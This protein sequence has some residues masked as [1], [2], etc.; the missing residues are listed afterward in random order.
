LRPDLFAGMGLRPALSH[1]RPPRR[2]A[3]PV[4][5]PI[6]LA[7][8]P[9]RDQTANTHQP[10]RPLRGQPIE[11]PHLGGQVPGSERG[12]KFY[13]Q[14]FRRALTLVETIT[15]RRTAKPMTDSVT[16]K[17]PPHDPIAST[18]SAADD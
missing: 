18:L 10:P 5:A 2:R 9:R 12:T 6:Q 13:N 4:A 1:I 14:T 15:G 11:H 16:I 8:T 3:A 17:K 7:S